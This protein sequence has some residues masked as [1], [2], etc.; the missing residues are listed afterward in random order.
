MKRR[1]IHHRDKWIYIK[2][3]ARVSV[4]NLIDLEKK[5]KYL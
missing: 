5:V 3:K 2:K 1:F 4:K